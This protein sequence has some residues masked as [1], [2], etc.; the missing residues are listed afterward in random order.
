MFAV[1]LQLQFHQQ[2]RGFYVIIMFH[3]RGGHW[4]VKT[5]DAV[6]HSHDVYTVL[7]FKWQER[8]LTKHQFV[9]STELQV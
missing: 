1:S 2:F 9:S 8:N 4:D 3:R 6:N 7:Q 5:T